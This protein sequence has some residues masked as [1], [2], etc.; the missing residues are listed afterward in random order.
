MFLFH[1]L[2]LIPF[3]STIKYFFV[4]AFYA[5]KLLPVIY[6]SMDHSGLHLPLILF[7]NLFWNP[8]IFEQ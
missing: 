4:D 3:I 2:F 1:E 6:I 5:V 7:L 8:Y